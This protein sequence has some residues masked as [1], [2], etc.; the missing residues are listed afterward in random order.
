MSLQ[1]SLK[2]IIFNWYVV[3]YTEF[4][5]RTQF[6]YLY[7]NFFTS[8]IKPKLSPQNLKINKLLLIN[9]VLIIL[10]GSSNISFAQESIFDDTLLI[11]NYSSSNYKASPANLTGVT[12]KNNTILI[13]ND[14]GI[15]SY[16][17]SDWGLTILP[18]DARA[19]SLKLIDSLILVGGGDEFGYLKHTK[20][21]SYQYFSLR[22]Q[23]DDSVKVSEVYMII[24]FEN[25]IYF[26]SYENI[27]RWDGNSLLY[28]I[29]K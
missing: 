11:R 18:N 12:L 8:S 28:P 5:L 22:S 21:D 25:N 10:L 14:N 9:T 2:S 16:N 23:L 20:G 19:T 13:A 27:F 29:R 26:Q 7:C 1:Q 3:L 15:L 17:G 24:S 6:I 4:L